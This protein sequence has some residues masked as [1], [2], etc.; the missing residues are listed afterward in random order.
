MRTADVNYYKRVQSLFLPYQLPPEPINTNINNYI[1]RIE[2]YTEML[3]NSFNDKNM[4][5][6][7]DILADIQNLLHLVGAKR[8]EA[9]TVTLT[10][11]ARS[12]NTDYSGKVLQQAIA[13]FLLLSIEMQ[14]A[15]NL[16]ESSPAFRYS[17]AEKHEE[18]ARNLAAVVSLIEA[19]D[20]DRAKSIVSDMVERGF[21]A[22]RLGLLLE[23]GDYAKAEEA[24]AAMQKEF[25]DKASKAGGKGKGPQ[26][27][28][29]VD[30]RPE[31]LTSVNIALRSHFKTLGAPSGHVAL[32]IMAQYDI[33][34]FILDI[35]MPE[36]DGFELARRIRGDKKYKDTPIIFLTGNSSR[37]RIVRAIKLDISDFIVKPAYNET[38]LVKVRKYLEA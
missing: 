13:D 4:S 8:Q 5:R 38:L 21:V 2:K 36:M 9:Y 29:A 11:S 22:G 14:R 7:V 27:V 25:M 15:Q 19:T 34:L 35:D 24:A 28:L 17:D 6:F 30:D 23:G 32:D 1:D 33:G 16:P 20:Y 37:D 26:T 31:I 12:G 10:R 18:T 3:E